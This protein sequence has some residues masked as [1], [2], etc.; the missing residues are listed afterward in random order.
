[1]RASRSASLANGK[2]G[3]A[4]ARRGPAKFGEAD[5][6]GLASQRKVKVGK[7]NCHVSF[8]R[9]TGV[10]VSADRPILAG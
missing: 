3:L 6:A 9:M 10:H 5:L 1:V 8:H 2:A 4:V 7:K